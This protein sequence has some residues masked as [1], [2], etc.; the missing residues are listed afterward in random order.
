MAV[1]LSTTLRNAR[2]NAIQTTVGAA[3]VLRLYTG[4]APSAAA[5]ASSGTMLAE[6]TLP[7][8]WLAAASSGAVAQ[9]GT[10]SCPSAAATGTAGYYRIFDPTGATCHYQGDVPANLTGTPDNT[11]TLGA[12]VNITGFSFTEAGA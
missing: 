3:A 10:W 9:A 11:I 5:D 2:A 12:P 4:T 8:T 1:K 7:T 6:F